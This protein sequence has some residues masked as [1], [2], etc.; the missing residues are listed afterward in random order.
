MTALTSTIPWQPPSMQ[1]AST[2]T[3]GVWSLNSRW[4]LP[5]WNH[6]CSI[7]ADAREARCE[8][9][10]HV[11]HRMQLIQLQVEIN[12]KMRGIL[13]DWLVEVHLKFKVNSSHAA[14]TGGQRW[15]S[16]TDHDCSNDILI[17]CNCSL[18]DLA[19]IA[20]TCQL[21][22]TYSYHSY[23]VRCKPCLPFCEL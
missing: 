5:T 13:V 12:A 16:T 6:R 23:Q 7:Y 10:R 15:V 1:A 4:H 9:M 18:G 11:D 21:A 8:L 14:S 3:T 22:A 19:C 17:R 2:T 20:A